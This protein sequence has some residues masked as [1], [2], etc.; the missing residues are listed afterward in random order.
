VSFPLAISRVRE[1]VLQ[2]QL[3]T[4]VQ[5]VRGLVEDQEVGIPQE[6]RRQLHP[7][8]PPSGQLRHGPFQVSALDLETARHL[9]ASPVG[10]ARVPL[11]KGN[12]RFARQEGIVLF[13]ISESQVP[14]PH[15]LPAVQ[16]L[17]PD[18]DPT[19]GGL[20]RAVAADDS[21]LRP[22]GDLESRLVEKDPVAVAFVPVLHL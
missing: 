9:S 17:V 12:H 22:G 8:P 11:E 4:Q 14:S 1:E 20:A 13:E 15:H 5:E 7:R 3:S 19:Q 2:E 18:Q 10:L 21:H 6:Q 16:I